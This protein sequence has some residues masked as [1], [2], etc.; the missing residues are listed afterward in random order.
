MVCQP[1]AMLSLELALGIEGFPGT[2]PF[3]LGG[4]EATLKELVFAPAWLLGALIYL[5]QLW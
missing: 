5:R 4:G 2:A 1:L 3:F